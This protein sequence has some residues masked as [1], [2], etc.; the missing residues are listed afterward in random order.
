MSRSH[1]DENI[2][3]LK[4]QPSLRYIFHCNNFL[5]SQLWNYRS[6]QLHGLATLS[7]EGNWSVSMMYCPLVLECRISYRLRAVHDSMIKVVI[8]KQQT[9][10]WKRETD[11][12]C[13]GFCS[14]F[15]NVSLIS[16]GRYLCWGNQEPK[17][18]VDLL[19]EDCRF[20]IQCDTHRTMRHSCWPLNHEGN[21]HPL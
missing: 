16:S 15:L 6:I 17:N 18:P 14:T 10:S 12:F 19:Q 11:F 21:L 2:L 4:Y 13:F 9:L 7:A 8:L 3:T 20:L 5:D 1:T